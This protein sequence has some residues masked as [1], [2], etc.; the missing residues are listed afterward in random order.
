MP[1][2]TSWNTG[3]N[4]SPAVSGATAETTRQWNGF[5]AE[6]RTASP[7]HRRGEQM[8]CALVHDKPTSSCP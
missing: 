5:K 3:D 6:L 1:S 7:D 4:F 2:A 8:T